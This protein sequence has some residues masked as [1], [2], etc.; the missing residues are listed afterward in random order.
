MFNDNISNADEGSIKII[1]TG[2][3]KIE[4]NGELFRCC[5]SIVNNQVENTSISLKL[6]SGE[7]F[8]EEWREI[9]FYSEPIM[10]DFSGE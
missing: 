4:S 9:G 10:I 8:D 6:L 2:S 1:F 7:T 5:F 3:Q